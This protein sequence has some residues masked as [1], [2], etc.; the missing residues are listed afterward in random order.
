MSEYVVVDNGRWQLLG[1]HIVLML[2]IQKCSCGEK[3]RQLLLSLSHVAQ[4][5]AEHSLRPSPPHHH[6]QQVADRHSVI[7][8]KQQLRCVDLLYLG[9]VVCVDNVVEA[10]VCDENDSLPLATLESINQVTNY[11]ISHIPNPNRRQNAQQAL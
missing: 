9:A 7:I 11:S 6:A 3:T 4:H 5:R 1:K 10:H 8:R 2:I